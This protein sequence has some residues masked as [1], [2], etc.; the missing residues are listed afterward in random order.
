[1]VI[2]NL[3]KWGALVASLASILTLSSAAEALTF[4][5]TTARRNIPPSF[6]SVTATA[7]AS[8]DVKLYGPN[9]KVLKVNSVTIKGLNTNK[10]NG[11]I[12][13]LSTPTTTPNIKSTV[14]LFDISLFAAP[15]SPSSGDYTFTDTALTSWG[16]ATT[17]GTY[18]SSGLLDRLVGSDFNGNWSLTITDLS[19]STASVGSFS[20]FTFDADPHTVPFES[21][22]APAGVAIVFGAFVLRRKLQQRS[23]QKM[24]EGV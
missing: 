10:R 6:N 3:Q 13:A 9:P 5:S 4:S 11:L 22:A 15:S 23:A 24:L 14:V 19:G 1:M 17:A 2:S 12:A 18:K 16:S 8:S 21:D 20:G 7:T